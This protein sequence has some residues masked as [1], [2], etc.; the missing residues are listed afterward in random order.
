MTL[1]TRTYASTSATT[2]ADRAAVEAAVE[3]WL[4]A[5]AKAPHAR[6]LRL[7]APGGELDV[8][9]AAVDGGLDELANG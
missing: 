2:G 4:S 8:V 7:V 5:R 6:A 9:L 1:Q 3:G